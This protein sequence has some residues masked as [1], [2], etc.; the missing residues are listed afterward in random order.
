MGWKSGLLTLFHITIF[1]FFPPLW[2]VIFPRGWKSGLLTL[3]L[4]SVFPIF[5]PLWLVIFPRGVEIWTS[6]SFSHYCLSHF[7][8]L[9]N[10]Y[11]IFRVYYRH[12]ISFVCI[13]SQ[14][15]G[16]ATLPPGKSPTIL[17]LLSLS[18]RYL[19]RILRLFYLM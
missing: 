15:K 12:N 4:S 6:H 10:C 3:F 14:K 16:A 18:A 19:L 8:T 1:L 9:K 13:T 2:L 7:S 11:G 5:P 17:P